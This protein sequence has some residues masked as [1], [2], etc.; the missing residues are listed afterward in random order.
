ME[1][2][3]V[4]TLPNL[5]RTVGDSQVHTIIKQYGAAPEVVYDVHQVIVVENSDV[6]R[7]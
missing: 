6:L 5:A 2:L 1:N 7:Y 4:D 3:N